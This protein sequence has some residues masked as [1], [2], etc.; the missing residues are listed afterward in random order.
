MK[1]KFVGFALAALLLA[2]AFPAE[3][4]QPKKSLG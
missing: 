2:V 3:A 4:Q 1:N